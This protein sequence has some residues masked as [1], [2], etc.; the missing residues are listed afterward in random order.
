MS[1]LNTKVARFEQEH[2]GTKLPNA[3]K[4][5]EPHQEISQEHLNQM[6]YDDATATRIVIENSHQQHLFEETRKI[7]EALEAQK[8]ATFQIN[9]RP[10][11]RGYVRPPRIV[12]NNTTA[13]MSSSADERLINNQ[14]DPLF[15][16]ELFPS[17]LTSL[18]TDHNSLISTFSNI[19]K[20]NSPGTPPDSN[21]NPHLTKLSQLYSNFVHPIKIGTLNGRGLNDSLKQKQILDYLSLSHIDICGLSELHTQKINFGKDPNF[22]NHP[23]FKF[24]WAFEDTASSDPASGVCLVIHKELARHYQKSFNFGGRLVGVDLFFKGYTKLRL[25]NVHVPTQKKTKEKIALIGEVE[26]HIKEAL[27]KHF[28]LIIWAILTKTWIIIWWPKKR[29]SQLICNRVP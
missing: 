4:Y 27:S 12:I 14:L 18:T 26:K 19:L 29:E 1:L 6:T 11:G 21:P 3:R 5:V 15:H 13:P 8:E 24:F 25:I 16:N 7:N 20:R 17:H 23:I 22:V 28:H 2:Y 10:G 9:S